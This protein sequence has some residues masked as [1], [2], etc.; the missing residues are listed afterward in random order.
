[1][2]T[3]EIAE[4]LNSVDMFELAMK[5]NG[6]YVMTDN[7]NMAVAELDRQFKKIGEEGHD[8]NHEIAAFIRRTINEEIVNAP[9]EL[10][11]QLFDRGSIDE[12]DDY[13]AWK[14]PKNTLVAYEAAKGGNVDRSFLDISVLKPVWKNRQ[15]ETDISYAELRRNGWKTVSLLT[16]YAMDA[17]KNAMFYDIFNAL[18]TGIV[19]SA[20]NYITEA[21]TMPTQ[22]SMDA[23]ALYLMEHSDG[24]KSI[25]GL[26]KYI[27]AASKLTGFVSEDMKNEVHRTGLLGTY[28]GCDMFPINST[29]KVGGTQLLIPD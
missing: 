12:N 9:D 3:V 10:L 27:Q 17:L 16:E 21:T 20:A 5:T 28:D 29:K 22:A 24:D 11:D 23:M 18:D 8:A 19:Y 6:N 25:V 4:I 15:V 7:E 2:N 1:M 13:E 26:S 14:T